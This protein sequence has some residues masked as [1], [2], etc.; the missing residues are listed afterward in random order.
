MHDIYKRFAFDEI[1]SKNLNQIKS[2]TNEESI[3]KLCEFIETISENSYLNPP[4]INL[5]TEKLNKIAIKT[6]KNFGFT[7]EKLLSIFKELNNNSSNN[8]YL[9]D[10]PKFE[11][12]IKV[13]ENTNKEKLFKG[14]S[15][16]KII[17]IYEIIYFFN[18]YFNNWKC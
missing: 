2:E 12:F 8:E 1:I 13:N 4:D 14:Y 11:E 16:T 6:Q 15:E 9:Q 5:L 7:N 18:R 10:I 17:L 3:K